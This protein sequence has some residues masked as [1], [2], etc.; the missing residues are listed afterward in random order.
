[1]EN[2]KWKARCGNPRKLTSLIGEKGCWIDME[3]K[4]TIP[5]DN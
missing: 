1:M 3:S 5:T 2:A 4:F